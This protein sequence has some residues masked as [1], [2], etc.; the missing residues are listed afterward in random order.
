MHS[1][2]KN[3]R[4]QI[5]ALLYVLILITTSSL[6]AQAVQHNANSSVDVVIFSYHRPAQLYALCESLQQHV[7]SGCGVVS[8]IYRADTDDY[9]AAY[10]VVRADFPDFV[11]LPQGNDPRADFKPLTLQAA[12]DSP[13]E[14]V[15]L[16]LMTLLSKIHLILLSACRLCRKRMRMAFIYVWVRTSLNV[17]CCH[18]RNH[19]LDCNGLRLRLLHGN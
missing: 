15:V 17:I 4:V 16:L 18:V 1:N 9:R 2:M 7:V 11:F 13:A 14:Y 3:I 6:V 12:F 8:V 10:E 5:K 19:C